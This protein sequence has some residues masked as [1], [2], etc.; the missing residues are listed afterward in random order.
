MFSPESSLLD[1]TLVMLVGPTAVGKSTL[2]NA[3]VAR[4]PEFKRVTGFT[5]RDPRPND[6][7]GQYR[8]LSEQSLGQLVKQNHI[9]QQVTNPANGQIYGTTAEDYPGTYN[10]KDTLSIAVDAFKRI[11]FKQHQTF[12]LTVP[13]E[14][15]RQWLLQRYPDPSDERTSR[16]LEA[17]SSIEWSLGQT[18]AHQ[19]VVN[20]QGSIDA[21]AD[22][23]ARLV[24]SPRY[25]VPTPDEPQRMLDMIQDLLSYG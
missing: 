2:M 11:P 23:L 21:V 6:E 1:K 9:L 13:V 17:K 19:W 16:L 18:S 24:R 12:S 15:W 25:D 20:H 22:R 3:V 8:Y 10:L 14:S 5:T 4:H 7:P